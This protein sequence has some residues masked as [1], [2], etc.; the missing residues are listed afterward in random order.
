MSYKISERNRIQ[1]YI[2]NEALRALEKFQ[3]E[4][5]IKSTS[6]AIEQIIFRGAARKENEPKE[7]SDYNDKERA[8]EAI[9]ANI[10]KSVKENLDKLKSELKE[11][12]RSTIQILKSE[13]AIE[14][15]EKIACREEE[16]S[17][18]VS[19]PPAGELQ[20]EEVRS[21][22]KHELKHEL[23]KELKIALDIK[24]EEISRREEIAGILEAAQNQIK[25]LKNELESY[26]LKSELINEPLEKAPITGIEPTHEDKSSKPKSKPKSKLDKKEDNFLSTRQLAKIIGCSHSLLSR[27]RS[28]IAKSLP[29]EV[30]K[31]LRDYEYLNGKWHLIN[32][33]QIS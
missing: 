14:L 32:N 28:G 12:V 17:K 5:Q 29:D 27:Y 13:L 2:S 10:E 1:G 11:E 25:A 26:K 21:K 8:I 23:K 18:I 30:A 6:Q 33:L 22:L 7:I 19:E 16:I 9:E 15:Q 20:I 3:E 24:F 4:N 31:K